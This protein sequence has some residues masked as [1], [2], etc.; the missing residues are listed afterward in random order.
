M[1]QARATL[2]IDNP[3]GATGEAPSWAKSP[4]ANGQRSANAVNSRRPFRNSTWNGCSTNE[5]QSRD[6]NRGTMNAGSMRTSLRVLKGD[7][8]ANERSDVNRSDNSR[9]RFCDNYRAI[10]P[11]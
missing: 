7:M 8:I 6:P 4:I 1:H 10:S 5:R 3:K 9:K 11:I 2:K